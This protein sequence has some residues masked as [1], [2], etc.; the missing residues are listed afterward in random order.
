MLVLRQQ[1]EVKS[2][3]ADPE[4]QE[5]PIQRIFEDAGFYSKLTFNTIFKKMMGQIPTAY[6]RKCLVRHA[7]S[8]SPLPDSTT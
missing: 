7:K 4:L 8:A 1:N 3:L 6:R 5:K 2:Q